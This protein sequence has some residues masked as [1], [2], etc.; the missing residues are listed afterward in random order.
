MQTSIA[1][2]KGFGR[3]R[4]S[5][6]GG[7]AG[8]GTAAVGGLAF[9]H[10]AGVSEAAGSAAEDRRIFK[11]ALLLEYLQASFYTEASRHG[12]LR[13]ELRAFAETVGEQERAHVA[14]LRSALGPAAG[15]PPPLPFGAGRGTTGGVGG[16]C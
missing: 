7:V 2:E 8:V 4:R 3:S 9:G 13:G 6:L 14:S 1:R 11:F 10:G 16:V 5:F 12:A 15:R